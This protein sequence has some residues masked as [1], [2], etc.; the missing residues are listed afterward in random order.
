MMSY[1]GIASTVMPPSLA[2][3]PLAMMM[4][5]GNFAFPISGMITGAP[6]LRSAAIALT[7]R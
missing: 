7:S 3:S 6:G 2:F 1:A 5:S 4:P